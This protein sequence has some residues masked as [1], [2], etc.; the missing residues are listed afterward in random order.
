MARRYLVDSPA[1]LPMLLRERL[2]SAGG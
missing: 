2:V 1:I